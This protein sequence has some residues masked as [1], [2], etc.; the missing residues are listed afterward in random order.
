[1]GPTPAYALPTSHARR[2]ASTLVVVAALLAL[3][4]LVTKHV[5]VA[6]LGA[7]A[8]FSLGDAI[9]LTL[10][11]NQGLAW[12]LSG[13]GAAFAI[14]IAGTLL[15]VAAVAAIHRPL[16]LVDPS[17]PRMLGLIVG[18]AL[19]NATSL[20]LWPAGAPDFVAFDRG[21]VEAVLNVADFALVVGLALCCR[22]TWRIARA[23]RA[24][25]TPRRALAERSRERRPV[26]R[27]IPLVVARDDGRVGPVTGRP[28]DRGGRRQPDD[29]R[30]DRP[31]AS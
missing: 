31:E 27:E 12:G 23:L 6:R 24:E 29:L 8:D 19:G 5:A 16:A 7:G 22:T 25:R 3:A 17:S 20:L 21:G 15:L 2:S 14:T 13:G 28:D 11:H 4:D 18:A 1:M 9:R 30:A 10:I 26:E